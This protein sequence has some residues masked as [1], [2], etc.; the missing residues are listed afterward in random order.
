MSSSLSSASSQI[1]NAF[2][3][4]RELILHSFFPFIQLLALI[5]SIVIISCR[6]RC[7]SDKDVFQAKRSMHASAQESGCPTDQ[8][9][10]R[11]FAYSTQNEKNEFWS[12]FFVAFNF[13]VLEKT[14]ELRLWPHTEFQI[15][16]AKEKTCCFFH[17]IDIQM[18][19]PVHTV[20]YFENV[21]MRSASATRNGFCT[22]ENLDHFFWKSDTTITRR[23]KLLLL[24]LRPWLRMIAHFTWWWCVWKRQTRQKRSINNRI[25]ARCAA[26]V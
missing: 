4:I 18:A 25:L 20:L 26:T 12:R 10:T 17:F 1:P 9:T 11:L 2:I 13:I 6:N 14:L 22:H 24:L 15:L 23:K 3:I 5:D 8:E 16:C 19:A 21:T 7:Q